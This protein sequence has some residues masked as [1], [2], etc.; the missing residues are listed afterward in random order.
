MNKDPA[1]PQYLATGA[2][3][4]LV[5]GACAYLSPEYLWY[6]VGAILGSWATLIIIKLDLWARGG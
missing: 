5:W 4:L 6:F 2:T 3:L 1:R